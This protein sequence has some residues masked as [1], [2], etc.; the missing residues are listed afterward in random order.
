[1]MIRIDGR[2]RIEMPRG[3]LGPKGVKDAEHHTSYHVTYSHSNVVTMDQ[4]P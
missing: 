2:L 3:R 4:C 1:V